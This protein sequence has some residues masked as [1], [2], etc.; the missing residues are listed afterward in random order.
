MLRASV[1]VDYFT[2]SVV[3]FY[4]EYD[5]YLPQ[6]SAVAT[7]TDSHNQVP[8]QID[9]SNEKDLMLKKVDAHCSCRKKT[10]EIV[11]EN[12]IANKNQNYV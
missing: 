4:I 10:S 1:F 2:Y 8:V 3:S 7:I 6:A 12:S 9:S 11:G 5:R